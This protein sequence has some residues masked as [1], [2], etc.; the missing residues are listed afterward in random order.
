[1]AR[2]RIN[3]GVAA[4]QP[5]RTPAIPGTHELRQRPRAS[6]A[7]AERVRRNDL[8]IEQLIDEPAGA[9]SSRLS[10]SSI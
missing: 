2:C 7:L 8:G 5:D 1:L 9:G 10:A 3:Q 6:R 4:H